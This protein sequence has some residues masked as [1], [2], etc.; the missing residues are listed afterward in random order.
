MKLKP[1]QTTSYATAPE[2]DAAFAVAIFA[3]ITLSAMTVLM[4]LLEILEN[5]PNVAATAVVFSLAAFGF[6]VGR[7]LRDRVQSV[8]KNLAV[9]PPVLNLKSRKRRKRQPGLAKQAS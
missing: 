6:A 8:P 4:V 7:A 5:A 3:L 2:G 1:K 9:T